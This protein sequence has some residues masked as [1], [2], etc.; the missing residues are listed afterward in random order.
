MLA[1]VYNNMSACRLSTN[2]PSPE[3]LVS[4]EIT[5]SPWVRVLISLLKKCPN[6]RT[7]RS[8][9]FSLYDSCRFVLHQSCCRR[10]HSPFPWNG[11][12]Q[13]PN[14]FWVASLFHTGSGQ[15]PGV[16]CTQKSVQDCPFV[17]GA[18]VA[19]FGLRCTNIHC[20]TQLYSV[21]WIPVQT[22]E[23][24]KSFLSSAGDSWNRKPGRL[25]EYREP[26]LH[27]S[28]QGIF[29]KPQLIFV[30]QG[31][32]APPHTFILVEECGMDI[33]SAFP[34][35]AVA[36]IFSRYEHNQYFVGFTNKNIKCGSSSTME[37][38]KQCVEQH[39]YKVPCVAS[40]RKCHSISTDYAVCVVILPITNPWY[41]MNELTPEFL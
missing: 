32:N 26:T 15:V 30:F 35:H 9:F 1:I 24:K 8:C 23:K 6:R 28:A 38:L 33:E 31:D 14:P 10:C 41:H 19:R 22:A 20:K 13:G 3:K 36:P 11:F 29:R 12:P 39:C 27:P 2:T 34:P 4:V 18:M 17:K 5:I 16:D 40:I 37:Q 21:P 25:C 7:R